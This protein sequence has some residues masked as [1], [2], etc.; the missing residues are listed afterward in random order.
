LSNAWLFASHWTSDIEN[1]QET[2][3]PVCCVRLIGVKVQARLVVFPG[4]LDGFH[5]ASAQDGIYGK[6]NSA[7][8][9]SDLP[10]GSLKKVRG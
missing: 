1:L 10:F 4:E 3:E 2:F 9:I 5:G 8:A 6:Q 7:F